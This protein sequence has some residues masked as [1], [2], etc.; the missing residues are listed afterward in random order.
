MSQRSCDTFF[1]A[2][3]Q[4]YDTAVAQRQLEFA[5]ALLAGNLTCYGTVYLVC[6]PV[7]AGNGFQLEYVG[8]VFVQLRQF[9]FRH[10]IMTF[11]GLVHHIGF[12]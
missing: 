6:Q 7:F 3:I 9:V 10:F 11:Y 4:S 8:K 12:G 2:I 1:A 5:L